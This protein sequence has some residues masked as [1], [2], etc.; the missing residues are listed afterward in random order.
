MLPTLIWGVVLLALGAALGAWIAFGRD[1]APVQIDLWWAQLLH[2]SRNDV[3]L[4]VSYFMN[5]VGGGWFAIFVVP[6]GGALVLLVLRRWWTAAAFVL[7]SAFSAVCVQVAKHVFGRARPQD[8]I[9]TSDFGS[10]PSG[11]TANAAT[12]AVLLVVLVPRIWTIVVGVA[13]VA[14]M[15]YSRT[16]LGAHWLTDT[17]GGA[18]LGAGA[19]LVVVAAFAGLIARE[20]GSIA[21]AG[22][23][24]PSLG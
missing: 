21:P 6:L 3:S 24:A 7:A 20:R 1:N 10:F 9:V 17:T 22:G 8:I 11:H 23:G 18:L 19:A 15:A 16:Q 5:F 12:I 14:L 4:A 2:P 13:W